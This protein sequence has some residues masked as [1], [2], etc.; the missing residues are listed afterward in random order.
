M[1]TTKMLLAIAES[2]DAQAEFDA[3]PLAF[4]LKHKLTPKEVAVLKTGDKEKIR[5]QLHSEVGDLLDATSGPLPKLWSN[6]T[7]V[8]TSVAPESAAAGKVHVTLEGSYF[9]YED[10]TEVHFMMGDEIKAS[11][12]SISIDGIDSES[13][14]LCCDADLASGIY[15]V[16]M[17]YKP[18]GEAWQAPTPISVE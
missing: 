3:D 11:G 4:A 13:S 9:P 16:S 6:N 14:K 18:I 7:P 15:T 5:D 1:R 10:G 2:E 12:T 17:V 8:I